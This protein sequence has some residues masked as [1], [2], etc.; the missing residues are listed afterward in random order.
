M[1]RQPHRRR[2]RQ[3]QRHFE[4][5]GIAAGNVITATATDTANNTSEFSGNVAVANG[6]NQAPVN[7]VPSAQNTADATPLVFSSGKGNPISVSDA[8]SGGGVEQISLSVTS[9]TL[10]FSGTAGLAVTAGANASAAM[11]VQG[12]L[13]NINAALNGLTYV[14]TQYFNGTDTLTLLSND[15]GNSGTGGPLTA[16]STV[17]IAVTHTDLAPVNSVPGRPGGCRRHALGLLQRAGNAISVSDADSLGGVEQISL[18][19]AQGTL[20]L[21][22]TTGLTVTAGSN[23]AVAMTVRGTLA[24]LNSALNGLTYVST[25]YFNGTDTLTLV[26]NDLG[27]SGVGGPKTTTSTVTVTVTHTNLAPVTTVPGEKPWPTP[28]R[29]SSPVA[30]AT[31]SAWAM[32]IVWAARNRLRSA[33]ARVCSP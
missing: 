33:S 22:D 25:Q 10:T 11:T 23:G 7:S 4:R 8:D 28:L 3:L 24:N 19:V 17:N 13:A 31:R 27:N 26:S 16:T 5:L 15:L 2:L 9:G 12:T 20:T 14:S 18:S 30:T 32:P 21:G 6:V 1:A 29:W